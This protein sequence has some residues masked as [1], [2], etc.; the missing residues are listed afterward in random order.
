MPLHPAENRGYRELFVSGR[1]LTGRWARLADALEG[2]GA[3][4]SLRAAVEAVDDMLE[5]LEPLTTQHRRLLRV[6]ES[7]HRAEHELA[8]APSVPGRWRL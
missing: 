3:E 5:A 8:H 2:S 1:Q 7:Q 6:D 4:G